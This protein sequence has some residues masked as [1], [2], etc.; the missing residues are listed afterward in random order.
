MQFMAIE[1][2]QGNRHTYRDDLESFFYVHNGSAAPS[3]KPNKRRVRPTKSSILHWYTR[4]YR[5]IANTRRGHM[6]GFEDIIAEFA[7]EFCSIMYDG[8][9]NEPF[10]TGVTGKFI[11]KARTGLQHRAA[12]GTF[13]FSKYLF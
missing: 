2:L 12:F 8:M 9:I 10:G 4:D 6:V 1:V 3:S 7:L 11:G 13:C 5:Q